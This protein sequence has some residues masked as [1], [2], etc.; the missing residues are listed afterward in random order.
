MNEDRFEGV[1]G[2]KIFTR[3]WHP[4][5]KP[6]GVVVICPRLQLPQR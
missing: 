2:L 3:A 5:G 6:R 1:K 4:S